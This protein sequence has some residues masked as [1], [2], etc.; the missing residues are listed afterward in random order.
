MQKDRLPLRASRRPRLRNRRRPCAVQSRLL[1][2]V[3]TAGAMHHRFHALSKML[4]PGDLLVL[5][6][7]RVVNARLLGVK[8]SGGRVELL[9]E[10]IENGHGCA[11]P[12]AQPARRSN[13]A[14]RSASATQDLRVVGREWGVSIGSSFLIPVGRVSRALWRHTVATVRPALTPQTSTACSLPECVRPCEPGA[15]AAPTASLHFDREHLDKARREMVWPSLTSRCTSAPGPLRRF[16]RRDRYRRAI[17]C[18]VNVFAFPSRR[19]PQMTDARARGS[20]IVAVGTTVVRALE[21]AAR[22]SE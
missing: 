15:V 16:V 8:D 4:R 7:T 12:G 19:A 20:R 3:P 10:R 2:L 17:A 6:D 11:L 9:V 21:S 14:A 18:T 13:P 1:E 22:C 5:N